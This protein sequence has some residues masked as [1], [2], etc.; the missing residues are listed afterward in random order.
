MLVSGIPEYRLPRDV[1]QKE[2]DA[3]LNESIELKL[4]MRLGKDFTIDTLFDDG[5]GAVF[6][7]LGAHRSRKL[8]LENEDAEGVFP[9][10][11]FLKAFNLHEQE[12][13]HGHVGVIGGGNSAIDAARVARRQ[14]NVE[15]V[16]VYYRRTEAEMPAFPR[17]DRRRESRGH[18]DNNARRPR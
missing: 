13:A 9:A 5:Y 17:G 16:T 7:A 18:R 12:L 11:K 3:L 10:L 14:K 8:N 6:L 1:L 2:I 15:K 4:N